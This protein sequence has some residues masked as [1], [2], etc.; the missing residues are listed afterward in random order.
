MNA[1]DAVR[2]VMKRREVSLTKLASLLEIKDSVLA[3]RLHRRKSEDNNHKKQSENMTI[4]KFNEMLHAMDYKTIAVPK[5]RELFE[6]DI[7]ID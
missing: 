2:E 3:D 5:D 4:Q 7:E 6:G 1:K